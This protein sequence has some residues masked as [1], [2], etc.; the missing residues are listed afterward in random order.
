MT[1][2]K[3]YKKRLLESVQRIME[4]EAEGGG[5]GSWP[6]DPPK[7][8]ARTE[9][10]GPSPEE[11]VAKFKEFAAMGPK[12]DAD[13]EMAKIGGEEQ[14]MDNY[15]KL[16]ARFKGSSA[17]PERIK[18]PVVDPKKGDIN[19]AGG[20]LGDRMKKGQLDLKPPFAKEN[21]Q[22]IAKMVVETLRQR[23]LL[24]EQEP[25]PQGGGGSLEDKFPSDL[26]GD[27]ERSDAFLTKGERDGSTTDD[28]AVTM[29]KG[30]IPVGSAR[31]SQKQV[32]IDKS[33]WNIL[34]Y[35][36]TEKGGTAHGDADMIAIKDGNEYIILDGHHRWSSA[37][38]SGGPT[39]KV[40]VQIIDG[41]N[42][43]EAIAA[44]RAYGNARG[45]K[46]KA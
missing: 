11:V 24:V 19:D 33:L 13:G 22:H 45:N 31:P 7:E 32:Y 35:G 18:M 2:I 21:V 10:S 46:Q 20:D 16:S 8:M 25:A 41:L 15:K 43:E 23:G 4:Q 14:L 36:G 1:S 40:N 17:N 26:L 30:A 6:A 37:F 44:L 12:Q 28:S 3:I 29:T 42:M 9:S 38:L 34:N 39:A 27:K 5:G